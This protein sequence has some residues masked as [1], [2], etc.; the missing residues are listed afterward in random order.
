MVGDRYGLKVSHAVCVS[1]CDLKDKMKLTCSNIYIFLYIYIDKSFSTL[2]LPGGG[3]HSCWCCFEIPIMDWLKLSL[4]SFLS[5][6][7]VFGISSLG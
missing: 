4:H 3:N 2:C 1:R 6:V 7:E 5:L